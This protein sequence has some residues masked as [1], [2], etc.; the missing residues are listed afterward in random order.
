M[1]KQDKDTTE[2]VEK[3]VE[4]PTKNKQLVAKRDFKL[5]CPPRLVLDIKKGDDL[6]DIAEEFINNLKTEEVL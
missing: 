1:T 6:S 5:N 4:K 2:K 3:K